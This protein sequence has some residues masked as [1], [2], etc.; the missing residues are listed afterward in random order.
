MSSQSMINV[1]KPVNTGEGVTFVA[2]KRKLAS[3]GD[4]SGPEEQAR[5]IKSNICVVGRQETTTYRVESE[6]QTNQE[7]SSVQTQRVHYKI[8]LHDLIHSKESESTTTTS[9]I[10]DLF[11]MQHQERQY[12]DHLKKHLHNLG[13]DTRDGDNEAN[14]VSKHPKFEPHSNCL[15]RNHQNNL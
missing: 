13:G 5:Q 4:E 10:T 3:S 7:S 1:Y 2:K 9:H 14:G 11:F 8:N 12:Q 6:P 15:N